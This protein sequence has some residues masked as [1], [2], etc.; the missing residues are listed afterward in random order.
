MEEEIQNQE[1][2]YDQSLGNMNSKLRDL[3]EKQR[4][5]KDRLLL[6]G[7]NLI[8]IKEKQIE[9]TINLKKE[10][11]LI[12]QNMTRMVSFLES[13]SKEFEK[14]AR[15]DDVEILKKQINMTQ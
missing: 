14:F 4:I 2:Y 3:E 15:K 10:I 8:E 6:I 13:A 5:L 7:N 12:K 9:E 1:I 11:Q